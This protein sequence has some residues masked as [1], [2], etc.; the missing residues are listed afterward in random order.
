M[1]NQLIAWI[2]KLALNNAKEFRPAVVAKTLNLTISEVM[3]QLQSFVDEGKL[4]LLWELRCPGC[5]RI[6]E[7]NLGE[8]S[9]VGEEF[10]CR[11]CEEDYLIEDFHFSPVYTFSPDY[12][13]ALIKQYKERRK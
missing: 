9:L 4:I 1:N 10:R 12:R 13:K 2:E 5:D 11:L 8:F 7:R 6:I 3:Q